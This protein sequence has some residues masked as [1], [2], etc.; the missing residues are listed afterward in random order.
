M[1]IFSLLLL[2]LLCGC[3]Q[4]NDSAR[5]NPHTVAVYRSV[6]PGE[7]G[8]GE[9][10]L[11]NGLEDSNRGSINLDC[12]E[13]LEGG[14]AYDLAAGFPRYRDGRYR[15]DRLADAKI[16]RDRLS[17]I[18][19]KH[20]D[21]VCVSE[22]GRLLA[23]QTTANFGLSFLTTT[24]SAVSTIVG[25]E[26]AKTILSG[27]ATISSGTQDN[28][29]A[30]FYRNQL[31]QAIGKAIDTER[32]RIRLDIAARRAE[33]IEAYNVDDMVRHVNDYH[34]ACSFEKGLQLLL[35]A[36]VDSDGA[37][38]AQQSRARASAM[39]QLADYIKQLEGAESRATANSPEKAQ[40][41]QQLSEARAKL[42]GLQML[43][44]QNQA[45]GD[46]PVQ[47]DPKVPV[48]VAAPGP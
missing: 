42:H 20:A 21:D 36:A 22:K 41:S 4:W 7:P 17:S 1:R 48:A 39:V 8:A 13:F 29:N 18:L 47:D 2:F 27:L 40:I 5:V 9:C 3:A 33:S 44:T 45:E 23:T 10:P 12:F 35:D 26:R 32:D 28:V 43:T 34:Q 16:A 14:Y 15:A 37:S 30:T 46:A 6:E 19:V 11:T 31:T 38:A 25:G 24:L